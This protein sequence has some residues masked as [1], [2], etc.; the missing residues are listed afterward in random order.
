MGLFD[1]TLASGLGAVNNAISFNGG[2]QQSDSQW[3]P[4]GDMQ[5][6]WQTAFPGQGGAPPP[7]PM[8]PNAA[9]L[10]AKRTQEAK[11]YRANLPGTIQDAST[12]LQNQ[13]RR[14]LAGDMAQN[15]M[16]AN[17]RGLLGSGLNQSANAQASGKEAV[18]YANANQQMTNKL[19]D[20]ADQM[21]ANAI[22]NGYQYWQSAKAIQDSAYNAA[23]SNMMAQRS[24]FMGVLNAGGNV[25][26]SS[27]S[28]GKSMGAAAAGG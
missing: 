27:A 7:P 18:N 26:A 21:D 11:D 10:T 23:L 8:D 1:N 16:S 3:R 14:A 22:N 28:T 13:S 17:R 25:G 12:S 15:N 9:A 5:H 6:N 20:S 2:G 4:V 19:Q 24:A